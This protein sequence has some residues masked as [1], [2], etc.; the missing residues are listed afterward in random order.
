MVVS[1]PQYK[2][3]TLAVFVALCAMPQA[4]AQEVAASGADEEPTTLATMTVTAQKREEALQDV[5]IT[6]TVLSEQLLQD[7]GVSDI[8]DVQLLVPGLHVSS[9]T[10][11]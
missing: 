3:L 2:V 10:N 5:P 8:K 1:K 7:A 9:T 4:Y 11:E 6:M